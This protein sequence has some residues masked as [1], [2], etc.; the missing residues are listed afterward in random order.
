MFRINA[1]DVAAAGEA[2][3]RTVERLMEEAEA[4][5]T[6]TFPRKKPIVRPQRNP[7]EW[8]ANLT[9][10]SNEDGSAID[11]T[12]VDQLT[13]GEL[14]GRRQAFDAFD[15]I[16]HRTPGFEDSYIV[17]LAPQIGIRETRRV[18]GEY[19]LTEDDVLDC[20]DFP[21][22]IGVNGWPVEAHVAGTVE[23]RW[24]R[25]EDS[26]RLQ[27]AAL[28]DDRAPAGGQPARR[29]A[30]RVDDPRRAVLGAGDRALL[31]DG[32]GGRDGGRPGH[33]GRRGHRRRPRAGAAAAP[34]ARRRVPRPETGVT[35]RCAATSRSGSTP[36][37]M[38][39]AQWT[40]LGPVRRGHGQA[41]DRDRQQL[42]ELASCFSHLDGI[43]AAAQGG[44]PGGRREWPSRCAPRRPAT[45]SPAPAG[46]GQYI[47]PSRDL[48]ASDIEVAVEGA[49]LDGMV[50]LASCDKTTPGQ[51]MAAGRLDIPTI[52]VGCG[53][54][55]IRA[56]T[57]ASTSTS[58]TS[59]STPATS[60]RGAHDASRSS[61]R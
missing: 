60:P 58:R 49:Q 39:R 1:V 7:L 35:G 22:T 40:A 20:A 24:Q 61:P 27:P 59:S 55:P 44:D 43:V 6:H 32:G 57:A 29:R 36:W 13:R 53:Y 15:F 48:I 26:A 19:Q 25:G 17:D 18:L 54:Q 14:Q 47:L 46:G 38:R 5:G 10:L 33:P 16:Q 9:Q 37:A 51:L 34:G 28:P 12:D 8:R 11:G 3:W 42:V 56:S 41:Q 31:R 45:R 2:P 4:A 50:C 52:V 30:V 23:F 21:D